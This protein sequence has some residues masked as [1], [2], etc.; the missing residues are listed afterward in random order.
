[1]SVVPSNTRR[2][3]TATGMV[4][5]MTLTAWSASCASP[6]SLLRCLQRPFSLGSFDAC[7][8]IAHRQGSPSSRERIP[9]LPGTA[10]HV[11]LGGARLVRGERPGVADAGPACHRARGHALDPT[12]RVPQARGGSRR[13]CARR[14]TAVA[15]VGY[16]RGTGGREGRGRRGGTRGLDLHVSTPP[17]G[18]PRRAPRG[19]GTRRGAVPIASRLL[20]REPDRRAGWAVHRQ[21][22]SPAPSSGRRAW[23]AAHR[24]LRAVVPE[25]DAELPVAR[26]RASQ[27]RRGVCR[28][29]TVPA[30]ADPRL[31][32]CWQ[33]S[34][35][36]GRAG[37]PERSTG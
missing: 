26:R 4:L 32:A 21:P 5:H 30:E 3:S 34:V 2:S 31:Q 27:Q 6:G 8:R 12:A 11:T 25:R 9:T 7:T 36:R 17:D 14:L 35:G 23:L 10:D 13:G 37:R 28:L 18:D 19:A 24:Q 33:L 22:T 29:R 16:R 15:I 20:R 1:M